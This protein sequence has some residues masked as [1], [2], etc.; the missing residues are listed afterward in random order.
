MIKGTAGGR[1]FLYILAYFVRRRFSLVDHKKILRRRRFA[2]LGL[3]KIF[4]ACAALRL[5]II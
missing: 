2:P 5:S 4:A 3:K 1:V